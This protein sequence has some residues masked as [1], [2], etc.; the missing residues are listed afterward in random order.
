[1]ETKKNASKLILLI[2]STIFIV[3]ATLAFNATACGGY[4]YAYTTSYYTYKWFPGYYHGCCWIP[5]HCVAYRHC[6]MHY[7]TCCP[8]NYC[9]R[10]Y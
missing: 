4:R 9:D 8:H 5:G 2:K 1:M 10:C 3:L 7:R 6:V